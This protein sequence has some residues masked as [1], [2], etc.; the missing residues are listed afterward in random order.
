M[1]KIKRD[2]NQEDSKSLTSILSSLN[3][4][5]PFEVVHRGSETQLQVG[6]NSK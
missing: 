4:L 1:L 2:I 6:K 5:Y 3:I